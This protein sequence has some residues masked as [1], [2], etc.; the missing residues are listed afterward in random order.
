LTRLL[1]RRPHLVVFDLAG[2]TFV[3]SLV[4]GALVSF[5]RALARHGGKVTPAGLQPAVKEVFHAAGLLALFP[6][7]ETVA[8]ALAATTQEP[9]QN[10]YQEA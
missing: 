2:L 6:V 3:A 4:L 5:R 7:S 10:R 1:A 9:A 8:E